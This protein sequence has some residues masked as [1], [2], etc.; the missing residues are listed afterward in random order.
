MYTFV[1]RNINNLDYKLIKNNLL[2]TSSL[3]VLLGLL[4][5]NSTLINFLNF[6]YF[7]QN[8]IGMPTLSVVEGNTWRGFFPSA[9]TIGEFYGLAILFFVIYHIKTKTKISAT[10]LVALIFPLFGL[11]K[12]NNVSA[13]I[14]LLL[15]ASIYFLHKRR[16]SIRKSLTYFLILLILGVVYLSINDFFYPLQFTNYKLVSEALVYSNDYQLSTSLNHIQNSGSSLTTF[17]ISIIST[18]SFYIN[19]STLWGMFFTR[20]NPTSLELFLGTGPFNLSKHYSQIQL[21]EPDPMSSQTFIKN[22]DSFLLPHSSVLNVLLYFGLVGIL[23]ILFF[24]FRILKNRNQINDLIFYPMVYLL[25]NL[26][27]DDSILYLPSLITLMIFGILSF[28]K[29]STNTH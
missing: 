28:N 12:S 3:V 25:I 1:K 26:N 7:G 9:E 10:G 8:K 15:I 11:M 16:V 20:Y 6:Y 21:R 22:V 17:V 29:E 24:I 14:A 5:A 27:K 19:R 23:L 4:G 13:L 2:V 18:I